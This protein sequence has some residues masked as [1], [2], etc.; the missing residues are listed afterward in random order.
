MAKKQEITVRIYQSGTHRKP[1]RRRG[2]PPVPIT[3][4]RVRRAMRRALWA[5]CQQAKGLPRAARR[6]DYRSLCRHAGI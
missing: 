6:Q 1:L 2:R 4:G 3:C 5:H